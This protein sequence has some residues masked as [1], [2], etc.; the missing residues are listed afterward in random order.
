[1]KIAQGIALA[2]LCNCSAYSMRTADLQTVGTSV[3]QTLKD[4]FYTYYSRTKNTEGVIQALNQN[5][6][7]TYLAT[8]PIEIRK[9]IVKY[10]A[11]EEFKKF[12][13]RLS[14]FVI[15]SGIEIRLSGA[16]PDHDYIHYLLQLGANP[17]I[18]ITNEKTAL[19]I[20]IGMLK[21]I[22]TGFFNQKS[23]LFIEFERIGDLIKRNGGKSFSDLNKIVSK[24]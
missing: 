11:T 2:I 20:I 15:P 4:F 7:T 24:G 1:M 21:L 19:D 22:G 3:G 14:P 9:E 23:E 8:L 18:L 6:E 13:Y 16:A 5:L 12:F 10:A 17:N